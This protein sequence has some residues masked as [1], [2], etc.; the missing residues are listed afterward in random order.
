MRANSRLNKSWRLRQ[1]Y[2]ERQGHQKPDNRSRCLGES[3]AK[4]HPE[5]ELQKRNG[6]YYNQTLER[7]PWDY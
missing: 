4:Y 1:P 7:R 2:V 5:L 3:L 6:E